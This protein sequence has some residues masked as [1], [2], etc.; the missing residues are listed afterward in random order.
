MLSHA[1]KLSNVTKS[2][3]PLDQDKESSL[4]PKGNFLETVIISKVV[5]V[6]NLDEILPDVN[7]LIM[8]MNLAS[9]LL[10][11]AVILDIV[12]ENL[13]ADM[14]NMRTIVVGAT[15][16]GTVNPSLS[17]NMFLRNKSMMNL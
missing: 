4:A 15:N 1:L 12:K 17:K 11:P 2:A 14:M 6:I 7:S 16:Q 13:V 5:G 10:D 8:L 9:L 3:V